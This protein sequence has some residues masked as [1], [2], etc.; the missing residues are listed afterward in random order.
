LARRLKDTLRRHKVLDA[1][2]STAITATAIITC[3]SVSRKQGGFTSNPRKI[4]SRERI[5]A[6]ILPATRIG[7]IREGGC[8]A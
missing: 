2:K 8:V 1:A 5:V 6:K 4:E 7:H 3:R